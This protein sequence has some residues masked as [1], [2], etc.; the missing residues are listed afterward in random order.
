MLKF[1]PP[2]VR[3][4]PRGWL[5]PMLVDTAVATAPIHLSLCFPQ[6]DLAQTPKM[7]LFIAGVGCQECLHWLRP[8]CN[9]VSQSQY[10]IAI[11][12]VRIAGIC[13]E[14]SNVVTRAA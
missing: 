13:A 2:C 10:E 11:I 8:G 9:R 5:A 4:A 7:P 1:A 6:C 12:V 14:V 3:V